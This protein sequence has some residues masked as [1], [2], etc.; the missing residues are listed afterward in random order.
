MTATCPCIGRQV[1]AQGRTRI[2]VSGRTETLGNAI[3]RYVFDMQPTA[4]VFNVGRHGHGW[5]G[6]VAFGGIWPELG[7][8]GARAGGLS[9]I[10]APGATHAGSEVR[11]G[12]ATNGVA[13]IDRT[14]P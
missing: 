14:G 4:A 12:V 10:S 3:E 1:V 8:A 13:E 5:R 6:K 9:V 2:D 11:G 7:L